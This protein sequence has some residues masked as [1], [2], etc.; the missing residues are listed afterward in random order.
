MVPAVAWK[1]DGSGFCPLFL[2]LIFGWQMLEGLGR[3]G[4][5]VLD[6]FLSPDCV[7]GLVDLHFFFH[8]R[9]RQVELVAAPF[10][11]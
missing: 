10:R 2:L 9:L 6:G 5:G 8:L 11:Y 3:L 1:G 4:V 7:E